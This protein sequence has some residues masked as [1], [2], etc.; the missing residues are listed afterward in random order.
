MYR[1]PCS[2]LCVVAQIMPLTVLDDVNCGEKSRCWQVVLYMV[3]E[4]FM[5]PHLTHE[6]VYP[7]N[8][9]LEQWI[10]EGR[11]LLGEERSAHADEHLSRRANLEKMAAVA[12]FNTIWLVHHGMIHLPENDPATAGFFLAKKQGF[13]IQ[14]PYGC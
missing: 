14:L 12:I 7:S 6:P 9:L 5:E 11:T 10:S 3:K 1:E 8:S 4:R 13:C 2:L